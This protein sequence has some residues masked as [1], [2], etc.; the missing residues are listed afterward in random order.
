MFQD[1]GQKIKR[2]NTAQVKLTDTVFFFGSVAP[3]PLSVKEPGG[4]LGL[5]RSQSDITETCVK[6]CT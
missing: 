3:V 1:K 5:S 4:P 2:E 6:I